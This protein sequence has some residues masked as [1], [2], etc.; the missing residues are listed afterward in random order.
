MRGDLQVREASRV[1]AGRHSTDSNSLM[2]TTDAGIMVPPGDSE[3]LAKAL[4]MLANQKQLR[5]AMGNRGRKIVEDNFSWN[6]VGARVLNF[7][8][9]KMTMKA[10]HE[11]RFKRK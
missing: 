2:T 10:R 8:E 6:V 9:E 7:Y 5:D 1:P 3:S 11:R 4:I